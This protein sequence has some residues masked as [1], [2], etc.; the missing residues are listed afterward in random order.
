MWKRLLG[1]PTCGP[2]VISLAALF[3]ITLTL[4]PAD[5]RPGLPEGPGITLDETFN[6]QMGVFLVDLAPRGYGWE[7]VNPVNLM[8]ALEAAYNPDDPP[9]GRRWLGEVERKSCGQGKR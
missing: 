1:G 2:V 5:C 8:D 9:M 6:V 7:I 3:A 4:D